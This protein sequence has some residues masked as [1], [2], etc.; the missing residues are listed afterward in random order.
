MLRLMLVFRV[1]LYWYTSSRQ[2]SDTDTGSDSAGP[3][4]RNVR[5]V[6]HSNA[7]CLVRT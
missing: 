3:W 6:E 5:Y 2:A 7:G 4:R 1:I